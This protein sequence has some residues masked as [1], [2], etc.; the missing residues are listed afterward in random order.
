MDVCPGVENPRGVPGEAG[1]PGASAG[2]CMRRADP[3]VP[4]FPG[5]Q[6]GW[7]GAAVW[8]QV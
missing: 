5:E 2:V 7:G 8:G 6:R 3:V 4:L 1:G